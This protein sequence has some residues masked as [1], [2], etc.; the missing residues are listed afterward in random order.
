MHGSEFARIW[1]HYGPSAPGIV[2]TLVGVAH[3]RY[4]QGVHD[5]GEG[6]VG[7]MASVGGGGLL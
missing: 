2:M 1:Y 3:N 4:L 7:N 6:I 5:V